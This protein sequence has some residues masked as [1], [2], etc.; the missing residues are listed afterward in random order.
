MASNLEMPRQQ[1]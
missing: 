1:Q